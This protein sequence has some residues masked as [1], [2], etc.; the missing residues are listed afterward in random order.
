MEAPLTSEETNRIKAI[1][2]MADEFESIAD[3][4]TSIVNYAHRSYQEQFKFD[5]ETKKEI[6]ILADKCAELYQA[7]SEKIVS[8]E[9]IDLEKCKPQWEEI[10]KMADHMKEIHLE[11]ATKGL[12]PPVA[13]LTLSDIV[14]SFRRIKNHSVNLAQAYQGGKQ[15]KPVN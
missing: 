12:F 8:Y 14:V 6:E 2:R 4:C 15:L 13:S 3:Y 5:D 11:R 10:N 9:H 7:V 1:L